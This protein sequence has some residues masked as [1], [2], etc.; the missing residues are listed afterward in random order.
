MHGQRTEQDAQRCVARRLRTQ[1][2]K[3]IVP[4]PYS[5]YTSLTG[6]PHS[7]QIMVQSTRERATHKRKLNPHNNKVTPFKCHSSSQL[8]SSATGGGGGWQHGISSFRCG[9]RQR[10]EVCVC[11]DSACNCRAAVHLIMVCPLNYGYNYYYLIHYI[12]LRRPRS[13]GCA[14]TKATHRHA[15]ELQHPTAVAI[16]TTTNHSWRYALVR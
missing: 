11:W 3:R 12:T 2:V 15:D 16:R 10:S 1:R 9:V 14:T 7:T 6:R 8:C 5:L 4:T 13:L